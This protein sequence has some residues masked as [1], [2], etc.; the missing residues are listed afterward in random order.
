MGQQNASD[1]TILDRLERHARERPERPALLEPRNPRYDAWT[2]LSWSEYARAV[3]T[4]ARAFIA[5]G[6]RP[7]DAVGIIGPNRTAWVLSDLAAIAAG[8]MPAGIYATST[9]EQAEYI[10]AHAGASIAVVVDS[11]QAQ[12]VLSVRSR[13][14][15]LKAIVMFPD[16]T[17]PEGGGPEVY[18]WEEMLARASETPDARL[19]ELRSAMKPSDPATLIYTSGTTGP[20]KAV[21]L[22]H[23]NLTWTG[24]V[25]N[26]LA[27]G[28]LGDRCLSYLPLAHVAEQQLTIHAPLSVGATVHFVP[29]MEQLADALRAVHPHVFFGVPRVW[30]KIQAKV[31]AGVATAPAA[32]QRL[33]RMAQRV[34]LAVTRARFEGG[35]GPMLDRIAYGLFDRLVYSKL[36][37]RLGFDQARLLA[38]G[39]APMSGATRDW[40]LSVGLGISEVYG[41]SEDSGP[42]SFNEFGKGRLGTVGT[43]IPGVEVKIAADGEILVHGP[44][45]FLG[46]LHDEAATREVL[47]D[48][49]LKSG[50]VGEIDQ[51]GY[52]R[53]TDRKKDLIITAGGKNV[54]P[55]NIEKHLREI[56]F[57][58]QAVVIGDQRKYLS[59]LITLVPEKVE[60]FC[61]DNGIDEA[62]PARRAVHPKV[63]AE[64]ERLIEKE[65]NGK[66]AQY[67][68][69]K[70]FEILPEELSEAA[71]ELTPTMKIKRKVVNARYAA[72][73]ERL[74][75]E[76]QPALDRAS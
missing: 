74:Y 27:S 42:T 46:Y 63:R 15:K 9:P 37:A 76:A 44:N 75:E 32:R 66:L 48:G 59:A 70:R 71:G 69:I 54:A 10:L 61:R 6:H 21:A 7:Q 19:D 51:N 64:L 52:L 3:R 41:Q 16:A 12:K 33:F 68:T 53:I 39:A 2:T 34:G 62:A 38:T 5:L 35:S 50:D 25:S 8:G 72:Q 60:A 73:I 14:P 36:K 56:P 26:V 23:R 13:L 58:S 24:N 1:I 29:V 43:P 55:Q 49:W 57:V 45:V 67:E 40:F 17:K 31:E 4:V 18:A 65:V 22:S 28:K 30:E 11:A 47:E 20:P